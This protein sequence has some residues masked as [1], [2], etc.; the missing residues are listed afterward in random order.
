[1]KKLAFIVAF[2]LIA[3]APFVVAATYSNGNLNASTDIGVYADGRAQL[4]S[5]PAA[6][7][8]FA[9]TPVVTGDVIRV[10]G[11]K[12]SNAVWAV[13]YDIQATNTE[14]GAFSLGDTG[15]NVR[16]LATTALTTA[17]PAVAYSTLRQYA[18]AN[19]YVQVVCQC[20]YLSNGVLRVWAIVPRVRL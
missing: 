1:M 7:V 8:N 16:F 19:D 17:G 20:P 5:I 11:I 4:I 12:G 18:T 15:S 14:A 2:V 6:T 10:I 3:T 13:G 9:L